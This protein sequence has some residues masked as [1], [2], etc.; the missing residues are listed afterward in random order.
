M[1]YWFCTGVKKKRRAD[2]F[3]QIDLGGRIRALRRRD[4]K[5]GTF[6]ALDGA[7]EHTKKLAELCAE[8]GIY[9]YTAPLISGIYEDTQK[10]T[11]PT[12][13]ALASSLP[14]MWYISEEMCPGLRND[15][16][17]AEWVRKLN[18]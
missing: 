14:G 16:R 5:D 17:W 12:E 9:S 8:G 11:V 7:L 10:Y 3:M 2:F 4:D 1:I 18:N 6:T 13:A 15:P